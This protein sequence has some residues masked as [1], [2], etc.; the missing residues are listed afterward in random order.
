[1]YQ[2]VSN[3]LTQ[4]VSLYYQYV[5]NNP[6]EATKMLAELKKLRKLQEFLLN[7]LTWE[8][9]GEMGQHELPDELKNIL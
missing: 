7:S 2:A 4:L 1:M 8:Q 5:R 9:K 3:R 6:R